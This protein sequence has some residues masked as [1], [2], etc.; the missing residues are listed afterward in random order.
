MNVLGINQSGTHGS[1]ALLV[2]GELR[3]VI[4]QERLSRSKGAVGQFPQAAIGAV[5]TTNGLE[6]ADIDAVAV[7]WNEDKYVSFMP[8]FYRNLDQHYDKGDL[9]R[10]DELI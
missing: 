10:S 4:E 7:G 3:S 1:A 5:L 6:V 2:D 8:N 9:T